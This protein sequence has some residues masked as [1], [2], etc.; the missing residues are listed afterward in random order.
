[1]TDV[2]LDYD[3]KYLTVAHD[4]IKFSRVLGSTFDPLLQLKFGDTLTMPSA[5]FKVISDGVL[6][7]DKTLI[8]DSTPAFRVA[9]S[10][11]LNVEKIK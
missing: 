7:V 11:L 8:M 3:I 9:K 6:N 1:M 4:T 5:S 10:A 2:T